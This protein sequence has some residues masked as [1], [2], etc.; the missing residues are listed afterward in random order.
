MKKF[1]RLVSSVAV[2][3]NPVVVNGAPGV[4]VK[5][6]PPRVAFRVVIS[7]AAIV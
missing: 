2:I 7:V 4:G 1:R 5:V 3:S 6:A